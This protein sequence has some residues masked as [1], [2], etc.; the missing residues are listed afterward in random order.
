VSLN[1]DHPALRPPPSI[2]DFKSKA[3]ELS[4]R[5]LEL[6]EV[7]RI[8]RSALLNDRDHALSLQPEIKNPSIGK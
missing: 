4:R 5:L 6:Q 1:P 2:P 3:R 7:N 8:T